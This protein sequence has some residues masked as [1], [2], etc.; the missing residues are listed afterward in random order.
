MRFGG[1][2]FAAGQR[3]F[4]RG[5]PPDAAEDRRQRHIRK[6]ADVDL[7]RAEL[8]VVGGEREI[9][10]ADEAEPA[11]QRRAVQLRDGRL[12]DLFQLEQELRVAPPRLVRGEHS[13]LARAGCRAEIGPRA[14]RFLARTGDGHDPD[15]CV[16]VRASQ[17]I[18]CFASGFTTGFTI[19]VNPPSITSEIKCLSACFGLPGLDPQL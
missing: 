10:G 1:G 4:H 5:P 15:R 13:A 6:E 12:A 11:R 7:G 8:D 3:E 14:K 9:A 17:R 19:I 18:E 2:D 16:A